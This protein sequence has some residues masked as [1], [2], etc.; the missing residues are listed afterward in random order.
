MRKQLMMYGVMF[1]MLGAACQL[2]QKAQD[3]EPRK[4]L[5][6]SSSFYPVPLKELQIVTG[7]IIYVPIYSHIALPGTEKRILYLS[8]TLSIRN[9]DQQQRIIIT[10]V[11]YYDAHGAVVEEY[12]TESFALAS[13]ALTEVI[14]PQLDTRGGSDANF[15]VKWVAETTV[16]APLIEAIMAGTM[17]NYSFAFARP[18]RVVQQLPIK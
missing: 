2:N 4:Q 6:P 17:G 11:T 8:A 15:L 14:V 1:T 3:S 18:S 16:S 12:L 13:L 9:T 10:S 5:E 7:R